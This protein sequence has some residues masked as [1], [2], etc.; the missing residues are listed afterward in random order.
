MGHR[1]FFLWV[2]FSLSA[3]TVQA[4][5]ILSLELTQGMKATVPIAVVPFSGEGDVADII[6]QDLKNTGQF[7]LVDSALFP[8]TP[9]NVQAIAVNDWRQLAV[10]DV[11]VGHV[12][13]LGDD[14]YQVSVSLV[15][16]YQNSDKGAPSAQAVLFT[17]LYT[18][19]KSQL[20]A[21]S[22]HIADLIYQTLTG[23][24]GIFTTKVAYILVTHAGNKPHYQLMVSDYDGFSPQA[25]VSSDE[26]MMS[27]AW[28]VDGTKIA[29][30]SFDKTLPA[31]Y[32]VTVE[33]GKITQLTQIAGINGAPA[34]SADGK[35]L[36]VVMSTTGQAKI[37]LQDLV[38][39][40]L[41][42]LTKGPS[43]DTEPDFSPDGRSL[44]FTSNRG[45][46]P[47]IYQYHF[48]SGAVERL[49][50]EGRY[51][52]TASF[53]PDDKTVVLLHGE[54][55]Q[56]NIATVALDTGRFSLITHDGQAESP[57]FSPNGKM[58]IYATKRGGQHS[59][60]IV[61]NDGQVQL[62][63]PESNGNVQEPSWSPY[64]D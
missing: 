14:Q 4:H 17:K 32:D 62:R 24:R 5:A 12:K 2:L 50:Y 29:F 51:N 10:E 25:L 3:M 53:S 9:H 31:I 16:V 41:T 56:Y 11:I 21:L 34:W 52:A 60:A 22:H 8:A 15:N 36:A 55:H 42:Q 28:S 46:G 49:T 45:G 7:N 44:I 20:R 35:K 40:K 6:S 26:P 61:S 38:S 23:A 33:T 1:K 27:P 37:Y 43:I 58:V 57:S 30:V 48:G 59:L 39:G 63:L 64:L 18:G 54:N 13:F 47:Q 19:S